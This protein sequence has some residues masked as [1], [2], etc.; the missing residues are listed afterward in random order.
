MTIFKRCFF[1]PKDMSFS[2]NKVTVKTEIRL[3]IH[4]HMNAT[5]WMV[6]YWL[7]QS[8]SC[9]SNLNV[10]QPTVTL[11]GNIL[12]TANKLWRIDVPSKAL[13][14]GWHFL[15]DKLPTWSA[16]I[17][18]GIL[19]NSH[20]LHCIFCSLIVEDIYSSFATLVKEFGLQ[21]LGG[22]VKLSQQE[23]IDGLIFCRLVIWL[24]WKNVEDGLV[25]WFGW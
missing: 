8:R 10:L 19:T 12:A 3:E 20:D 18:R 14:F 15:L 6:T 7:F 16:L 21:Y 23:W 13:V 11:D 24:D 4:V 5:Y 17:H 2:I 22:W 9:Y 1:L 25:V